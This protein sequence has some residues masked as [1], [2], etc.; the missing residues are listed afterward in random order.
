MTKS[1]KGSA[2]FSFVGDQCDN[3]GDKVIVT[4]YKPKTNI[5]K[6]V[7]L[8]QQCIVGFVVAVNQAGIL[9]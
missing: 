5:E 4:T 9:D 6:Q 2:S 8:C 3:C 7:T 1:T